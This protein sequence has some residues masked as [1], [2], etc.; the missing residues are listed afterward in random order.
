MFIS[1]FPNAARSGEASAMLGWLLKVDCRDFE[2]A[3]MHFREPRIDPFI[4]C[5]PVMEKA[6]Y[7][8]LPNVTINSGTLNLQRPTMVHPDKPILYGAKRGFVR[9]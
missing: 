8:I 1:R 9:M 6:L 2:E 7:N 4:A 5:A 3:R